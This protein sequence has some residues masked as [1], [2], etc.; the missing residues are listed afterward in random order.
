MPSLLEATRGRDVGV[1]GGVGGGF[2][3]RHRFGLVIEMSTAAFAEARNALLLDQS[4][5]ESP[6]QVHLR[7]KGSSQTPTSTSS[8]SSGKRSLPGVLNGSPNVHES[9]HH[10]C[11]KKRDASRELFLH[12]NF[13]PRQSS[14]LL[15]SHKRLSAVRKPRAS[16]GQGIANNA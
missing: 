6:Q 5:R 1:T 8:S 10:Q 16:A 4:R 11:N 12:P 2:V 13:L 14:C 15:R 9:L 3:F 7:E